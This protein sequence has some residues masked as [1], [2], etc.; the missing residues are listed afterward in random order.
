MKE[1]W[2]E[3]YGAE[4][5]AYGKQPNV[6]FKEKISPLKPGRILLPAEGEGRN[7]VYAAKLGWDV[8]AYDISEEGKNKA[9]RLAEEN[10]VNVNYLVG[11]LDE[12]DLNAHSFDCIALIYAHLPRKMRKDQHKK[13]QELLKPGGILIVEVFSEEHLKFNSKNPLVGGPKDAEFL[14][15]TDDLVED[16]DL[17]EMLYLDQEVVSLKEGKFHIGE[18]SVIRCLARKKQ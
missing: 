13:L 5:Y 17:C 16:F 11:T 3:R 8:Y 18:G 14:F 6:Y 4:E 10:S 15:Q 1:F 12:L 9:K 2:N 7:A